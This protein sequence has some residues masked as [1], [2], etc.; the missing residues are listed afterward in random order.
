MNDRATTPESF[1][2]EVLGP[3]VAEFCLRLWS[4]T[5]L[6]QRPDDTALLFCARGGLR[7]EL[8]YERFL[9]STGLPRR[10]H[11]APVMVSR[12]VAVRPTLVR[13][14]EENPARLLP[15]A[16]TALSYEFR[17]ATVAE[18]AS[19][20]SGVAPRKDPRWAAT[21]TPA[22]FAAL[23]GHPDG[24]P[25]ACAVT[26][27]A[28]L[29][30]RHLHT[31]LDGRRHAVLVDTGLFGTTGQLLAEG[32]PDVRFSSALLA[33]S[34]R[35][36]PPNPRSFGLTVEATGY[37]PLRRRTALLRY[38]HLVEWLFEP[39]LPSVRFFTDRDGTA[40]ADLEVPDWPKRVPPPT[41]HPFAG[42]LDYLDTLCPGPA[43][44]VLADVDRAWTRLRRALVWPDRG[45]GDALVIGIRSHDFGTGA[46]WTQR[47]WRGPVAALRG[48]TMWREG[49]IA[50]SGS[51][52]RRPLLAAVEGAYVA[53]HVKR[54]VA[55]WTRGR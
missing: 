48:S 40:V 20:V 46:T 42:V 55:R 19:A 8:A 38:W 1:G 18:V 24:R 10:V 15:A 50:R 27:Q 22:G 39:D 45:H 37:S 13:G 49:E 31:A 12:V 17:S 3:I 43:E 14:I 7:M 41:G 9:A 28:A 5:A 35:S 23:L 6:L 26:A 11:A 54:T 44:R 53:R 4:L 33:R 51:V 29:F 34:Y 32:V 2:R 52:L 21:F 47:P 16:A 30:A 25:V 36:G